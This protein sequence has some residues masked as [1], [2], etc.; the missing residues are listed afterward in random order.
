MS[1]QEDLEKLLDIKIKNLDSTK[2]KINFSRTHRGA[3]SE[4]RHISSMRQEQQE[5]DDLKKD[6]NMAGTIAKNREYEAKKLELKE[7]YDI[8]NNEI[9]ELAEKI[10]AS[11]TVYSY[12][13]NHPEIFNK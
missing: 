7:R 9:Q 1:G 2:Q 10:E 11:K 6:I 3:V 13:E 12:I 4:G 5:I 8:L